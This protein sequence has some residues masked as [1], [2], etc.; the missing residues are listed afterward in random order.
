MRSDLCTGQHVIVGDLDSAGGGVRKPSWNPSKTGKSGSRNLQKLDFR[1]AYVGWASCLS[2]SPDDFIRF[3][4]ELLHCFPL[5]ECSLLMDSPPSRGLD[6][7]PQRSMSSSLSSAYPGGISCQDCRV[8]STAFCKP[9]SSCPSPLP[10]LAL[11]RQQL[12]LLQTPL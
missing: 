9:D 11:P 2:A 12:A 4:T 3:Q 1:G 6:R 8:L 10:V 7:N 5:S